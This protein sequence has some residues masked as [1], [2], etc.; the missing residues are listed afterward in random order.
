M[1]SS[2]FVANA[3]LAKADEAAQP[4]HEALTFR[5]IF[6]GIHRPAIHQAEVAAVQRNVDIADRAQDTIKGGIRQALDQSFFSFGANGIDDIVSFSPGLN[7]LLDDFGRILQIA[8]HDDDGPTTGLIDSRRDGRLMSKI[9]AQ[10]HDHDPSIVH[11][12]VVE[13]TRRG[14][15]AAV[16]HEDELIARSEREQ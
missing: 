15:A 5:Q 9:T 13:Y 12:Q 11:L 4:A 2:A 8:I 14:V 16:V 7:Q 6:K 3:D 10:L 1:A